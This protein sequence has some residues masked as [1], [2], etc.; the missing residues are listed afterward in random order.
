[1]S[2]VSQ[3]NCVTAVCCCSGEHFALQWSRY[4]AGD[5]QHTIISVGGTTYQVSTD[6]DR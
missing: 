3:H 6:I 4:R 1:M 5:H 2:A